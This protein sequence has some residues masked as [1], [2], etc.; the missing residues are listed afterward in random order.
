MHHLSLS[1]NKIKNGIKRICCVMLL[2]GCLFPAFLPTSVHAATL[3]ELAGAP[4]STNPL[5]ARSIVPGLSATY[6][7]PAL[8]PGQRPGFTMGLVFVSSRLNI[9]LMDRDSRYD[10]PSI[11]YE[12]RPANG[13]TD[14]LRPLP[15]DA[16][17]SGRGSWDPSSNLGYVQ[18][19]SQV[20]FLKDR[21][22]F[23][24]LGIFPTGSFQEQQPFF[25]DE[26]EQ[27]FS[28]SL[29]FELFEDRLKTNLVVLG[30]GFCA[31]AKLNLG[32]GLTMSTTARTQASIFMP[33][34]SRQDESHL[35]TEVQVN[36]KFIPHAGLAWQFLRGWTLTSTVHFASESRTDGV[37]QVQFWNYQTSPDDDAII[38]K[39]SMVY[40]YEPLR[41]HT[42]ISHERG[43]PGSQTRLA[44]SAQWENW[45]SYHDRHGEKPT[46]PWSDIWRLGAGIQQGFGY[47][48]TVGLDLAYIPTPV[49]DQTGR[50]NYVDNS[51]VAFA[52]GYETRRFSRH[53]ITAGIN[54]Q[55]HVLLKRSTLK[56][57]GAKDPVFD[58]FVDSNHIF[59]GQFIPESAGFQTNNPGF[60]GFSSSGVIFALMATL[61]MELD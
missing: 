16:L 14:M 10:V 49:P 48:H 57:P 60:P 1:Q 19:G 38:Q 21:L 9:S 31:T 40:G 27:Y 22:S 29:H 33:D 47:T 20:N 30:L 28:N 13:A 56:D 8:L 5:S 32:I 45:S 4:G 6:F 34:A 15:T 12:S 2:T 53:G 50:S 58:E 43:R 41:I 51:R 23:G 25:S 35:N 54:A 39:F 42:G 52:I 7:N 3:L 24:F 18:I 55:A 44:F 46:D 36:T 26:R 11:I 59:T 37:S 61:R 17:R